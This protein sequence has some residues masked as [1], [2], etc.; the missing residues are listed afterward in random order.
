M[1]AVNSVNA[2]HHSA[3]QVPFSGRS[4][5]KLK[6]REFAGNSSKWPEWIGIFQSTVGKSSQSNGEKMSHFNSLL[7]GAARRSVQGLGYSGS[8]FNVDRCT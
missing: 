1:G 7:T 8:M 5:T 3:G 6:M 2:D 4:S